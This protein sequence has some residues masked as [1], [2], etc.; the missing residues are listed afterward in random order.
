[1]RFKLDFI[2]FKLLFVLLTLDM[3]RYST[4]LLF[5]SAYITEF[6]PKML[7][8]KNILFSHFQTVM[9]RDFLAGSCGGLVLVICRHFV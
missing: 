6:K 1:M 9:A 8:N 7:S 3:D 5:S 2:F 4:G